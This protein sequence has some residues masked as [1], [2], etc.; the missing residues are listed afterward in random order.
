[1]AEKK[2][3]AGKAK[4]QLPKGKKLEALREKPGMSNAGK[5]KDVP[6]KDFAG[7]QGTFPINTRS[8]AESAL[9]L[10]HNAAD[11]EK[12]KRAVY[13]KYPEMKKGRK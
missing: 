8:R 5:Y 2:K 10:A 3:A 4:V 9:K 6:K 12:I 11:P 13:K 7:P 1:M